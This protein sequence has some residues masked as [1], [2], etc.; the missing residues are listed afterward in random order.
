MRISFMRVLGGSTLFLLLLLAAPLAVRGQDATDEEFQDFSELS[1]EELLNTT[2]TS[3]SKVEQSIMEAPNSIWVIT[4]EEIRRSGA[5]NVPEALRLAP[6]VYVAQIDGQKYV[7]TIGGFALNHYSN[8]IL[9]LI[10]G[11]SVY[12]G[13]DGWVEWMSLPVSIDEIER[14]EVIR[15][16]GGVTYGANAVNGVVNIFTKQGAGS[17]NYVNAFGGSQGYRSANAGAALSGADG[18]ISSR[19]A[20]GYNED[21]GLGMHGGEELYDGQNSYVVSARNTFDLGGNTRISL[22]GRY[23]EGETKK[24]Y[25]NTTQP[26]ELY[27][28]NSGIMKFRIDQK[29]DGG[30]EW[31][32]HAYNRRNIRQK[33]TAPIDWQ[34]YAD[35]RTTDLEFQALVP[36]E[37]LGQNKLIFGGGYRWGE[38]EFQ[39]LVD[40]EQDYTVA[41]A[42]V[43]HEWKPTEQLIWN[44]GVKYERVDLVDPTWQWRAALMYL[45]TKEHTFRVSAANAYRSPALSEMY[46]DLVIPLP[47]F[48]IVVPPGEAAVTFGIPGNDG[49]E[50]EQV[51]SYEVGYRGLWGKRALVDLAYSYREYD[52]LISIYNADPGFWVP[53]GPPPAP[54][55]GPFGVIW[56]WD[57][58]GSATSQSVELGVNYAINEQLRLLLNYTYLDLEVDGD[59]MFAAYKDNNP[60]NF[61]RVQLSYTSPK[62]LMADLS[63]RYVDE[64]EVY[65][66]EDDPTRSKIDDYWAL[67]ARLAQAFKMKGGDLEVGVVGAN[68]NDEWHEEYM[69]LEALNGPTQVRK[70]FYGY[71]EYRVK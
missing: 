4:A 35:S 14:I 57:D 30:A 5:R 28:Y 42:Y 22:D 54:L 39:T 61:G 24:P 13:R 32:F 18:K 10:D 43:Q 34:P 21:E 2:V 50:P 20:V 16:P 56:T 58:S 37:A 64:V 12:E 6:G 23:R 36:F 31:Y 68:L 40:D 45:P 7:V 48:P 52:H 59:H 53:S 27:Q 9:V 51:I 19:V 29:L 44:A 69:F 38:E 63:A 1:I 55:I 25:N 17:G 71:V 62:G 33:Y 3:S 65:A 11:V 41:N 70:S 67:D 47:P 15:G 26:D 8:K 49:L 60:R 66:T 46:N